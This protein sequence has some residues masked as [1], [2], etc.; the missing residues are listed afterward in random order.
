MVAQTYHLIRF[1]SLF[2]TEIKR[3]YHPQCWSRCCVF[4]AQLLPSVFVSHLSHSG[5]MAQTPCDFLIQP[6]AAALK[7]FSDCESTIVFSK[8]SLTPK[9]HTELRAAI[10]YTRCDTAYLKRLGRFSSH[11]DPNLGLLRTT[12]ISHNLNFLYTQRTE[13]SNC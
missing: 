10:N 2:S 11:H 1:P 8:R 6:A 4:Y 13:Y 9:H 3:N 12:I 7:P 5:A